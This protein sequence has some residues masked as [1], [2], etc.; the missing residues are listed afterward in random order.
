MLD[1]VRLEETEPFD[2]DDVK[3]FTN[4]TDYGYQ[5]SFN[6]SMLNLEL[7][8]NFGFELK[9][10]SVSFPGKPDYLAD[11]YLA[12]KDTAPSRNYLEYDKIIKF[13]QKGIER[14]RYINRD[15]VF[16]GTRWSHANDTHWFHIVVTNNPSKFNAI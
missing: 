16:H 14:W 4:L 3:I 2:I 12:F 10:K 7:M 9:S 13:I 15:N 8:D 1:L 5:W 6:V 11:V